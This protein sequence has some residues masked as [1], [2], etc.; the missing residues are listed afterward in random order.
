MSVLFDFQALLVVMILII[1]TCT[2]IKGY[3]PNIFT[4]DSKGYVNKIYGLFKNGFCN[5][6]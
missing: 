1:C 3:R 2:Y 4:K 6:G 5:W